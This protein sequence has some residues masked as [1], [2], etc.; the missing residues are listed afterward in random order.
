GKAVHLGQAK[1]RTEMGRLS[2]EKGL[3]NPVGVLWV[4]AL[5]C[6][7]H[8]DAGV[9]TWG[10]LG[11]EGLIYGVDFKWVATD[12]ELTT[13]IHRI[14]SVGR[15]VEEGFV[16]RPFV[17]LHHQRRARRSDRQHYP[18]WQDR[19]EPPGQGAQGGIEVDGG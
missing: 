16:E 6:V 7:C 14:A 8:G 4:D 15:E 1:P 17:D 2:G 3:P 11:E 12:G 18:W 9:I 10:E 5:S 19:I 13:R